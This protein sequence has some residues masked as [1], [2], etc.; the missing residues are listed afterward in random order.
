MTD[1]PDQLL[2][3]ATVMAS[4]AGLLVQRLRVLLSP[5][6]DVITLQSHYAM[7]LWAVARFLTAAGEKDVAD[8]FDELA[9]AIFGLQ[10]GIIT[11]P[12]RPAAIGGRGPDGSTKWL[13]RG[14]VVLGLRCLKKS[15]RMKTLKDAANY[16]AKKHPEEFNRLKRN[17]DD[18]LA[19]AIVSWRKSILKG[20]TPELK[21]MR[22]FDDKYIE[23]LGAL[24]ADDMFAHGER[25]LM[26]T[27]KRTAVTA[28]L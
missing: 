9:D 5:H 1:K 4:L 28:S 11:D 3:P 25:V 21:E 7:A 10:R 26:Q 8:R 17:T 27:V 12:V 18:D 13:L 6:D 23:R 24:S 22:V 16:I 19:G 15:G 20:R 14:D 2:D